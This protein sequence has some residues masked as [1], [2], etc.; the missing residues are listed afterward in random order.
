MGLLDS[1]AGIMGVFAVNYI[2]NSS[3][4]V[5][6][7]Q[8]AIPISMVI[9]SLTLGA[10]YTTNQYVG[11]FVVVLGIIAVLLPSFFS[12]AAT[13]PGQAD[14]LPWIALLVFACIPMCLSSVY[15]EKALGEVDIDVIYLNG[16]V[17]IFQVLAAIPLCFPSAYVTGLSMDQ[18][19]PNMYEGFLCWFGVNSIT[20]SSG[21]LEVDDCAM[22]PIYVNVYI[23]FNVVF[24]I[25]I[26][27]I[28]KHG[29][30]NIMW[31][32]S[33]VIVPL[34][35]VA[36]SL[37]FMPNHT[38]LH[39]ADWVGLV[40]IMTGLLIYRFYPALLAL[41]MRLTGDMS[42]DEIAAR[43]AAIKVGKAAEKQQLKY[44]GVNQLEAV[45]TLVDSRISKI[46]KKKL[47]RNPVQIR[48]SYLTRLGIPPSPQV[49]V[50]RS[51][52]QGKGG[53]YSPAIPMRVVQNK[54]KSQDI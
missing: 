50:V 11:A 2:T 51:P 38:T 35:N 18:I 39:P 15:K 4:I 8:S 54:Y 36:F 1:V 42:Q 27:V 37:N 5:L 45:E 49:T 22:A 21:N 52:F 28:L 16:W 29:S 10:R 26:I 30:A 53:N 40:V 24:N 43:D 31:M 23:A 46:Q 34:S 14:Q 20:Q 17:A 19:W 48:S 12:T 44:F 33:T 41:Y 25:L 9:S 13:V 6:V 3:I 32:A 7:Q 47:Y